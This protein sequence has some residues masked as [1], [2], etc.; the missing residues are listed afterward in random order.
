MPEQGEIR[1]VVVFSDT[2]VGCK[3]ALCHPDG[4]ELDDGGIYMPSKSQLKIWSMWEEFW[5]EWV[6]RVTRGQPFTVVHNGD[7]VDGVHH[8]STTQWSHNLGDQVNHAYKIL[9]PVVEACEGRYYHIRGTEA[10]VGKSAS[11]EERLAR[12]LNAIPNEEGQFARYEL[13]LRLGGRLCHFLHH[14]GTTS[15]S[16]HEASAI[17]AELAA[18][19]ADAGRF[20]REPPMVVCRSHRHRCGE[21]RLPAH[22]GYAT[23]MVTA[24]WQLKT[25]YAWKIAGAR[26][27]TPQIGGSLI[28]HGD[29]EL[30]TRHQV[31]EIGISQEESANGRS[32]HDGGVVGRVR[33]GGVSGRLPE[34]AD[35]GAVERRDWAE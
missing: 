12:L 11:E 19:Y 29:E 34:S 6:P 9:K 32:N 10:H 17:N 24:C 25:P 5:G 13:R 33:E 2:H 21:I 7:V 22:G 35:G 14:I 16:A 3:L 26:V 31:W 18:M 27:S 23:S 28:R 20:G 15:S 30:Y 4:A 8:N 1:N